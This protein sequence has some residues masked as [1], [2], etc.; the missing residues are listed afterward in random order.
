MI[1]GL[2]GL[3]FSLV[4]RDD[5]FRQVFRYSLQGISL[6]LIFEALI[7]SKKIDLMRSLLSTNFLVFVGKLSYSMYL[8]HWLALIIMTSYLGRVE[9][10]AAWQ[11]GY[12]TLTFGLS[13]LSYYLVERPT[14]KLRVKYGSHAG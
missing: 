6:Y 7:F 9:S 14:L 8:Y 3:I 10:T 11:M 5:Y 4:Y 1:L 2:F 13:A 12:W